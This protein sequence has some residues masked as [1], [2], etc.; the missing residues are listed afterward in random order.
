MDNTGKDDKRLESTIKVVRKNKAK[1]LQEKESQV[2]VTFC[3]DSVNKK[4]LQSA[5]DEMDQE[6]RTKILELDIAHKV[7][8]RVHDFVQKAEQDTTQQEMLT[9]DAKSLATEWCGVIGM[10]DLIEDE[11]DEEEGLDWV[12]KKYLNLLYK[13]KS[14]YKQLFKGN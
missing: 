14:S 13:Q 3:G 9:G 4:D 12:S 7:T 5:L 6:S 11:Y 2:K 8:D 1:R 10:D